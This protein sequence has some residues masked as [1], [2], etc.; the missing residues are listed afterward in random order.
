[1]KIVSRCLSK[2]KSSLYT[3]EVFHGRHLPFSH[4][5]TYRVFSIVLDLDEL[6]ELSQKLK[7]F[8]FNKWN[9]LSFH[10]KDHGPRD[11]S[12][13][14]EWVEAA[15]DKKDIDIKGGK[16]FVLCFP[17]VRG[18]VFSPLS[19]YFCYDQSGKLKAV[20]YQVKN[21][22]G[23]QHGYLLPIE[24]DTQK[25]KQNTDKLFYVS[26]FIQ[27]DCKYEFRV[28]PPEDEFHV[29]IHQFIE[30]G[31]ILTATWDGQQK[32]LSDDR[33]LKTVFKY[34]LMTLK[35]IVGIHYE[36][37]HLWRKGA[38]FYHRKPKEIEDVT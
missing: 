38:K 10:N 8:S 14:R 9:I 7:Y 33:I 26:P 27:M 23:E 31:K 34:P 21:T 35:V 4:K 5:F 6:P 20:L 19:V 3:G 17:R 15:A 18:Y 32:E 11:G 12:D 25:I 13:L 1:M 28:S 29:A 2:M 30:E 24:A 37:F 16:I 22:F 36:A